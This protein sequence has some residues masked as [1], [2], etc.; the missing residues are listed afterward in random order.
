[1]NN[2]FIKKGYKINGINITNDKVSD[3]NYWNNQRNLAAEVYQF[4]VYQIARHRLFSSRKSSADSA[5][6]K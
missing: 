3:T 5:S 4:P 6:C 2:Y 1:M